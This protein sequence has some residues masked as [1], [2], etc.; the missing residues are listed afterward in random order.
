MEELLT[1]KEVAKILK[2][3]KKTV[4]TWLQQGK[5]KGYKAGDLWR[6]PKGAIKEF[7]EEPKKR[8]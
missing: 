8:E 4:Y 7:L 2:V 3:P 5:L 1:P 6:V